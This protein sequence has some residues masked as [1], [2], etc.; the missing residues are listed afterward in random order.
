[1]QK[2]HHP[3]TELSSVS[4]QRKRKSHLLIKRRRKRQRISAQTSTYQTFDRLGKQQN[5]KS[6]S[7]QKRKRRREEE[8]EGNRRWVSSS[9]SSSSSHDCSH[10]KDR[11]VIVSYNI[12]GVGNASNHLDLY[13]QVL[14]QNLNWDRRKK[15]IQKELNLYMPSILCFQEVDR[16]NDL[17]DLLQE[18][19]YKG[20][21]KGRTG[22]ACDGCAIFWRKE[23]FTVLHQEDIEFRRFGLRDN[24]AQLCVLKVNRIQ[25][26]SS[27][28]N[29]INPQMA[30]ATPDQ[31]LL[32]GNIH[33]LF[34][35]N[36][37]D[38]K[39]GQVR[40]FLE[41]AHALSQEWGNIP[42]VIAGDLNSM[43][44]FLASSELDIMNH[45]R[46]K[47]SGQIGHPIKWNS[48]G[49]FSEATER[50]SIS[51][52][53]PLKYT[54]N[55]EEIELAAG[56]GGSTHL[57]HNLK[58]SSAYPGVPGDRSTRDNHGEPLATSCHSKFM[59]TVDY[60]WHSEDLVPVR[61]LETLP[62]NILRKTGGLPSE[63]WGSDH[64]A[65]VCELA[66][67]DNGNGVD[68]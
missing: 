34:N 40:L 22:E 56:I 35:P 8:E 65:L 67:A 17:A 64:L 53:K 3:Q 42:V 12:L 58:L 15:L 10:Y 57:R 27:N 55:E 68:A 18:D 51:I 50:S 38:V 23:Q 37:G 20:I 33:V 28:G 26:N 66:F 13:D 32:V 49:A 46:K 45:E 52:S 21:Y 41:K 47:I 39:L 48:F 9:S 54:W 29:G 19:G 44:Q 5:W 7:R 59:G 6:D 63:K 24:V 43:P 11:F 62:I 36:R 61:V 1:M 2:A 60:I 30:E 16:F 25:S 14:P 31:S 4:V